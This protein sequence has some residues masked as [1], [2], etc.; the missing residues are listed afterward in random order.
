MGVAQNSRARLTQVSVLGSICQGDPFWPLFL[1]HSQM[2]VAQ[3]TGTKN[4]T[5]VSGNM[6][7]QNAVGPSCFILSQHPNHFLE[8]PPPNTPHRC[9]P[10]RRTLGL[11]RRSPLKPPAAG[12]GAA[13]P[14]P[15][16]PRRR[17]EAAAWLVFWGQETQAD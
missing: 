14:L 8:D 16:A 15:G 1:G 12:G 17:K 9:H 7:T 10:G 3:K 11:T 4:G 6:G 13:A 2:A 5:L